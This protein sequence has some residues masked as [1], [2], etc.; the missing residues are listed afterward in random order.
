MSSDLNLTDR[1]EQIL[2]DENIDD[3][4]GFAG[5]IFPGSEAINLGY[6]PGGRPDIGDDDRLEEFG[7]A[8]GGQMLSGELRGPSSSSVL[9]ALVPTGED[10]VRRGAERI[11]PTQ[12]Q[13]IIAQMLGGSGQLP[14]D[15]VRRLENDPSAR[16]AG[17]T[18]PGLPF[19]DRRAGQPGPRGFASGVQY[20]GG[21]R[22]IERAM[23]TF[24][25]DM[26][27]RDYYGTV[28]PVGITHFGKKQARMDAYDRAGDEYEETLRGNIFKNKGG[29]ML[30]SP[31][32]REHN[33]RQAIEN[34]LAAAGQMPPQLVPFN[35][36]RMAR[37]SALE[38]E[39]IDSL[40]REAAQINRE[41]QIMRTGQDFYAPNMFD[42]VRGAAKRQ[43]RGG[44]GGGGGA[45]TV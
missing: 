6:Q 43:R 10:A 8:V 24:R 35:E 7:A 38:G 32:A 19:T 39:N 13:T 17:Q 3:E 15:L 1:E 21:G 28:P 33:R 23:D 45:G 26:S 37:A 22:G 16:V 5:V 27:G 34:Q 18:R 29:Q 44:G 20:G 42:Y 2:K 31:F 4:S 14:S 36:V 25:N 40:R 9:E 12:P 30:F 11:L 41:R